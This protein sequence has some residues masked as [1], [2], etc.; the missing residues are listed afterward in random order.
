MV[1]ISGLSRKNRLWADLFESEHKG[2]G[3]FQT[4]GLFFYG[5]GNTHT[6]LKEMKGG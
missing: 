5:H 3:W 4:H 2:R 1:F 6:A